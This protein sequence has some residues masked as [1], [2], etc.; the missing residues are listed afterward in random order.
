MSGNPVKPVENQP[1][2]SIPTDDVIEVFASDTSNGLT[3]PTVEQRQATYGLNEFP[4]EEKESFLRKLIDAFTDP[5][6]LVLTFAAGLS[7]TVGIVGNE[8]QELQQ[9]GWIMAIVVFMV[10]IEYFTDRRAASELAKLKNLQKEYCTVIRNGQQVEIE[11]A[12]V[13]PGDII[14]LPEGARVPSD[15]RVLSATN[16]TVDEALLTGESIPKEKSAEVIAED[17]PLDSRKCMV[18]SGTYVVSGNILAI[19]TGTGL[20]TEFGKIWEQLHAAEETLTPLQ[21]QLDT[22]GKFLL[23]GAL[24][25]CVMIAGIYIQV[26]G[27]DIPEALLIASALA[28][29]FIPEALGAIIVIALALGV[30]EMV[31]K[32]AII[33]RLYAAEGLGSVSVVC[34]DKTGTITYGVMTPTHFWTFDT[35]EMTTEK[36]NLTQPQKVVSDLIDVVTYCNNY[37]GPSEAALGKL[38][39]M[40][41]GSLS[42]NFRTNRLGEVPFSS[43]RK[44]MSTVDRLPDGKIVM[45]SKGAVTKLLP[46]S[47]YVLRGGEVVA[48][49][50]A[51]EEEIHAQTL[52]F[53][54]E[55]YRVFGFAQ[56][57]F[58]ANPEDVGEEDERDFVFLGLV[59]LSDPA[60]PE[61][62]ETIRTLKNA[63]VTAKMVTGD[64]PNTAFSI[65]RDIHL[66]EDD[67]DISNVVTSV[68]ISQMVEGAYQRIDADPNLNEN[69]KREARRDPVKYFTD[70]QVQRIN[71]SRVF[72]R[73]TP[74]DKVY[75][76]KAMQRAGHLT[77]MAGD[78]VNDAAALKQANVGIAMVNGADLTKDVSDVILTG[79]YETIASAVRIGRTILY[80][81]RLYTH[82][83][84][85]TN[86]SEVGLF[87][88]A[89][90][91]GWDI[92]LTA[93]QLLVIN[94]AGDSWLSIALATEKEEQDVMDKPP[95]PAEEPVINRYMWFSIGLQSVV[96][97]I[98]MAIAFV[99]GGNY[100]EEQGITGEDALALQQTAVLMTFMTQKILRSAF[101]A[102]SLR[103]NLWEIG[104]FTNR[105]SLLAAVVTAVLII[106]SIYVLPVGMNTEAIA[107]YP[108]LF[109][110]GF[111]PPIIEEL[112]KYIRKRITPEDGLKTTDPSQVSLQPA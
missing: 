110:L 107:L 66:V 80:R 58:S 57:D 64:S 71:E 69:Q 109:W 38:V 20:N 112:V 73:V 33:R 11:A 111:I 102:R 47:A 93:L 95:R 79:A 30:R 16:A 24:V 10:F 70:E 82:A 39:E 50:E 91:A 40:A 18:Y 55:G 62:R 78:G 89:A 44:M 28:I 34:T 8:T 23:T 81:T 22:L 92:P 100:A 63:G 17:T 87:I 27:Y 15:G 97:T 74:S 48:K 49:T 25:V 67:M 29:A 7:A 14:V 43:A 3:E 2:W 46:R 96:V 105:W 68:E 77:A 88:L 99:M 61:V 12:L 6:A 35:G 37:V 85:S 1:W 90:L 65:A 31:Q 51:L 60:R 56:R 41:G 26:Q 9:A 98:L 94:L 21:Q 53:E 84:L 72:A 103:F 108:Q 5:L 19:A 59:A 42:A 75:I 54:K 36:E 45:R 106:A 76:V 32:H 83:L 13:V 52:R 4:E 86:G 104:F 101:T